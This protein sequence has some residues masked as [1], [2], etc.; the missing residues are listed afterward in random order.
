MFGDIC[1]TFDPT[2]IYIYIIYV[3]EA[4]QSHFWGWGQP[5]CSMK[6][7][8]SLMR[9]LWSFRIN[10]NFGRPMRFCL[11]K[12]GESAPE[13][14]K[15]QI[16]FW[17]RQ[18][19]ILCRRRRLEGRRPEKWR[20]YLETAKLFHASRR[21]TKMA[22]PFWNSEAVSRSPVLRSKAFGAPSSAELL[23]VS[24]K[25]FSFIFPNVGKILSMW[26]TSRAVTLWKLGQF[27]QVAA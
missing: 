24:H 12:C 11:R 1:T 18:F 20:S 14:M 26:R 23:L 16:I 10:K 2:L 21:V 13:N 25:E 17:C 22:K 15:I 7:M 3:S 6:V 4:V 8:F 9:F 27:R 19:W 5:N